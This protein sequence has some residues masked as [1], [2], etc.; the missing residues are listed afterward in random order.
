LDE[1]P[2]KPLI[3][4]IPIS[5]KEAGA[6]MG[7]QLALALCE[8]Q[9]EPVAATTLL[10]HVRKIMAAEKAK[11]KNLRPSVSRTLANISALPVIVLTM[12]NLASKFNPSFN[13]VVSNV[14]G[15]ERSL[16]IAGAKL[17]DIVPMSVLFNGQA[18][19]ITA[20]SYAGQLRLS[21]LVCP[22]QVPEAHRLVHYIEDAFQDLKAAQ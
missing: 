16:Y 22:R 2:D 8:F 14:R 17:E 20:I 19:N 5:L 11:Y 10:E 12:L 21:V 4:S 1:L 15:P 9:R 18:L 13:F 3:A 6:Q 7:N